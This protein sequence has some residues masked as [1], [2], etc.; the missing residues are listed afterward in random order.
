MVHTLVIHIFLEINCL[1]NSRDLYN[2][3]SCHKQIFFAYPKINIQGFTATQKIKRLQRCMEQMELHCSKNVDRIMFSVVKLFSTDVCF[4]VKKICHI[5][6]NL[7]KYICKFS[8]CLTVWAAVSMNGN[9]P[10]KYIDN[11]VKIHAA[12]YIHHV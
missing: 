4:N 2:N 7:H 10:L 5:L 11:G 6:D 1:Q 3:E 8:N 12:Y 9:L